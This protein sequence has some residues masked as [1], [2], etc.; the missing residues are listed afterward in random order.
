M[1]EHAKPNKGAVFA[2][3]IVTFVLVVDAYV[4]GAV[5]VASVFKVVTGD[6][7]AIPLLVAMLV[8]FVVLQ[9]IAKATYTAAKDGLDSL[10]G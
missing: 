8:A 1:E 9:V 3:V 6:F 5:G 10:A 4:A 7:G 2:T